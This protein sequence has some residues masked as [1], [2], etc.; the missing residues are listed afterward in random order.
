M[1]GQ[2]LVAACGGVLCVQTPF[3]KNELQFPYCAALCVEDT[4][5][6]LKVRSL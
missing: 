1:E 2:G 4:A 6:T 3:F 5:F